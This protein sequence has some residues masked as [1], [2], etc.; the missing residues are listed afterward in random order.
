MIH[1]RVVLSFT[2]TSTGRRKW[3]DR[4]F[5]QFKKENAKSFTW[6]GITPCADTDQGP[7]HWEAA[8]QK[9]HWVFR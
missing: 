6:E 7:P 8:L 2:G 1:Q 5:M 4:K 9:W 3:A